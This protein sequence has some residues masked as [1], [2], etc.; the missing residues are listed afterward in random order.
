MNWRIQIVDSLSAGKTFRSTK[1]LFWRPEWQFR[2]ILHKRNC[3]AIQHS[4]TCYMHLAVKLELYAAHMGNIFISRIP[5]P[6]P[7]LDK[8]TSYTFFYIYR[9]G[10]QWN[11]DDD[12][13][14]STANQ[15]PPRS[16]PQFNY[17]L[18]HRRSVL[19]AA[20]RCFIVPRLLSIFQCCTQE[21]EGA[22]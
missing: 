5:P 18:D 2:E 17:P 21:K 9:E 12:A 19:A 20:C 15:P 16:L 8:Y 3:P 7:R 6:P 13:G 1:I 4:L 11:V 22:W 14:M 10:L